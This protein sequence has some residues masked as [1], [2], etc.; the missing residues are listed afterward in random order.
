MRDGLAERIIAESPTEQIC[1]PGE[2]LI[3]RKF[4]DYSQR[5]TRPEYAV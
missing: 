2:S 4:G 3:T 1:V 5:R